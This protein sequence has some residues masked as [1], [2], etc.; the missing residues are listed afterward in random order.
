MGTGAL[1][2]NT[3]SNGRPLILT[4]SH[5]V[6]ANFRYG[7]LSPQQLEEEAAKSVFFFNY[8]TPMCDSGIQPS[9]TQ[10]IAGAKM[11]GCHPFTDVAL[12]ELDAVPPT[13]YQVYYAGWNAQPN[14][15]DAHANIHH[16]YGYSKRINLAFS[17]LN[18]T[19]CV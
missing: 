13:D 1:V 8:Q 7:I 3:S 14:L 16:P 15:E 4:A 11:L 18:Y 19:R 10:S 12:M 2:N 6:E 9:A 17:H 5:V